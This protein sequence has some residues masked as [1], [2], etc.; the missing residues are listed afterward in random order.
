MKENIKIT[1]RVWTFIKNKDSFITQEF[2]SAMGLK[3]KEAMEILQHLHDQG[4]ITLKWIEAKGKLSF[5]KT[6]PFNDHVN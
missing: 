5:V 1:T 2:M 6:K 4:Y 3:E